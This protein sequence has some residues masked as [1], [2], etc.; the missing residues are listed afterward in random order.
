VHRHTHCC[1]A[2]APLA[3]PA[4][5]LPRFTGFP[6]LGIHWQRMESEALRKAYKMGAKQKGELCVWG[7]GLLACLQ[8]K[9]VSWAV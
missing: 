8:R 3:S 5:T 1:S 4:V 9:K 7:G 6:G 2:V